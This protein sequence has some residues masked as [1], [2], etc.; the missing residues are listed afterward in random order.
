MLRIILLFSM[1]FPWSSYASIHGAENLCSDIYHVEQ[2]EL[3]FIEKKIKAR[4]EKYA[5]TVLSFEQFIFL[6]ERKIHM[7]PFHQAKLNADKWSSEFCKLK[8]GSKRTI[9]DE[10]DAIR[11]FIWSALLMGYTGSEKIARIATCLQELQSYREDGHLGESS[12]M[13]FE[14][15]ETAFQY[16]AR[17]RDESWYTTVREGAYF[18]KKRIKKNVDKILNNGGFAVLGTGNSWCARPEIY[19]NR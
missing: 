4:M 14:N 19:P 12:Y 16:G 5:G 13:D 3:T 11:H 15:N 9:D 7:G 18:S 2:R 1:F 10:V 6:M 8:R 17:G